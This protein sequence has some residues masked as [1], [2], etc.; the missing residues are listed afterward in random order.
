MKSTFQ[1][2][3]PMNHVLHYQSNNVFISYKAYVKYNLNY[4]L[5]NVQNKN[6]SFQE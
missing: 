4:I 1:V 5:K 2:F 6:G 3:K